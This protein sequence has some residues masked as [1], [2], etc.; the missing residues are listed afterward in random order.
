MHLD[1][2]RRLTCTVLSPK[3]SP[4]LFSRWS[5]VVHKA[6]PDGRVGAS[7]ISHRHKCILLLVRG[8]KY[9]SL[10][11]SL[12]PS[13]AKCNPVKRSSVRNV[14]LSGYCRLNFR[15][16]EVGNQVTDWL[17]C[18]V[19]ADTRDDIVCGTTQLFDR[20]LV[21]GWLTCWTYWLVVSFLIFE[22]VA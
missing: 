13:L 8:E 15:H 11:P 17:P 10:W 4:A 21:L 22:L 2:Q 20:L 7:H 19:V 5:F 1:G 9:C 12:G 14:F 3:N 6:P 18:L 16:V